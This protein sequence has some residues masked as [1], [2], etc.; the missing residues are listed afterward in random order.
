MTSRK[1]PFWATLLTFLGVMVLCALGT[2]QL[3]RLEW[4]KDIIDQIDRAYESAGIDTIDLTKD[5]SYGR[6]EGM[7]LADKALL[8]GPVTKDGE[9]GRNLIVPLQLKNQTLLVNLGWTPYAL[10]NLPIYHR[11][12][13]QVAF[14]G[15]THKPSWNS[16]TPANNPDENLWY[17]LDIAEIA[18][19]KKLANPA[20]TILYA[21]SSNYKFDAAFPNNTRMY[22]HNNHAQYAAFWFSMAFVLIVIY[23]LRFLNNKHKT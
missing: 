22:P 5:F 10:E 23:S 13:K 14:E 4:K 11:N 20:P 19:A 12:N 21:E 2:W 1:I 15:M 16:F 17:K 6:V 18:A 3:Q 7:F 8:I 9:I